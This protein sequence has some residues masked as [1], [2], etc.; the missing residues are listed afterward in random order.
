[1]RRLTFPPIGRLPSAACAMPGCL[2]NGFAVSLEPAEIRHGGRRIYD[3]VS[4][5][6]LSDSLASIF[7]IRYYNIPDLKIIPLPPQ[8]A[9]SKDE[10]AYRIVL[11]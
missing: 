7:P 8:V 11:P 1:M 9:R 6:G 10:V 3:G 5:W 2:F 4:V